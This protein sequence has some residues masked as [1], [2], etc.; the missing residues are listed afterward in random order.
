VLEQMMKR[1]VQAMPP[2]PIRSLPISEMVFQVKVSDMVRDLY[3]LSKPDAVSAFM[4]LWLEYHARGGL[5]SN[6]ESVRRIAGTSAKKWPSV[7]AELMNISFREDWT[8]PVF[9]REI[10]KLLSKA[11]IRKRLAA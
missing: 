11:S 10:N 1:E 9:D 3:P 6:D 4:S 7:R 8:N 2:S 5:P